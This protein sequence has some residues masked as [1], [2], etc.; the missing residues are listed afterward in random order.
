MK[1]G[2]V[3]PILPI[4][5]LAGAA[6]CVFLGAT[7]VSCGGP[8]E[9]ERLIDRFKAMADLAEDEDA[10]G[11]MDVLSDDYGDFEGR[12][13]AATEDMIRGYFESYRGIVLH[14]LGARVS[15]L[16]DDEAALEADVTFSSGAVEALRRLVKLAGQYYRIEVRWV[17]QGGV[18][19]AAYAEWREVGL[20]DLLSESRDKLRNIL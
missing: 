20:D 14:V 16:R 19:L 17:K 12:D 6:V 5:L 1:G 8:S 9:E 2:G 3:R 13:K 4:R 18:W 11:I 7:L 15:D 10:A